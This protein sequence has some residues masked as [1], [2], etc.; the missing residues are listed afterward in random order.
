[1]RRARVAADSTN[2]RSRSLS[3][4]APPAADILMPCD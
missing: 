1:L 3:S 2:G 4:V